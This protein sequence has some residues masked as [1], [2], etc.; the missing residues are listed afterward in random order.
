MNKRKIIYLIMLFAWL[1]FIYGNS[2]LNGA[3]SG[4]LSGG[5]TEKIYNILVNIHVNIRIETLHLIIRKLA[6][7]TE[8]FILG[9]IMFLNVYQYFK[10]PKYYIGFSLGLCILASLIDE[11]IQTFIDGRSGSIV[12][13]GIDSIGFILSIL[14]MTIITINTNKKKEQTVS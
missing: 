5:I 6:H 8:F 11:T 3:T 12:D 4:S 1:A 10:E 14:I 2:L 9:I 7:I 13:V